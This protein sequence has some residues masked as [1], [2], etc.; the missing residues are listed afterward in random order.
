M[1]TLD[2]LPTLTAITPTNDDLLPIY[3]LT[4]NGSS[5]V[6]KVSIGSLNGIVTAEVTNPYT[7]GASTRV[8][9]VTSAGVTFTMPSASGTL[10]EVF[11]ITTG[12]GTVTTNSGVT[13]GVATVGTTT[14]ARFLSNGTTWYRVS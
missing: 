12:S 3:D 13:V 9:V 6:R 5:K 2:D 4:A 11:I 7:S 8:N 10:R 14:S 1:P